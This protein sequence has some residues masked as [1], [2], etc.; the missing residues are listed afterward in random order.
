MEAPKATRPTNLPSLTLS[1]IR[2]HPTI[3]GAILVIFLSLSAV[4]VSS[5][6]NISYFDSFYASFITYSTIGFGDLDIFVSG[7]KTAVC[8]ARS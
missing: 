2:F 3:I 7:E 6:E 8:I 4:Y 5:A 1:R